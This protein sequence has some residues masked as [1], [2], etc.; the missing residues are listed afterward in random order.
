MFE[1]LNILRKQEKKKRRR[2][3]ATHWLGKAIN[4]VLMASRDARMDM[5][6]ALK[7]INMTTNKS[8][9]TE[10]QLRYYIHNRFCK[11]DEDNKKHG[12]DEK[13]TRSLLYFRERKDSTHLTN[14]FTFTM[15]M[16]VSKY[17]FFKEEKKFPDDHIPLELF[18]EDEE[19]KEMDCTCCCEYLPAHRKQTTSARALNALADVALNRERCVTAVCSETTVTKKHDAT[20]E[21]AKLALLKLGVDASLLKRMSEN[22]AKQSKFKEYEDEYELYLKKITDAIHLLSILNEHVQRQKKCP[23]V[24]CTH[25]L[26]KHNTTFNYL[27]Q[28]HPK[29][30]SNAFGILTSETI[31]SLTVQH[32]QHRAYFEKTKSKG[33]WL[34]TALED[35]KREKHNFNKTGA[36]PK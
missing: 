22:E 19:Q 17:E 1:S 35:Y 8:N 12:K 26:E 3:M 20:N 10:T 7:A 6:D 34:Q 29:I 28:C 11:R 15:L 30:F 33:I 14:T 5:S 24:S 21:H 32:E 23:V 16:N 25:I 2:E 36:Q 27:S 31:S 13:K 18:H 4:T 9:I